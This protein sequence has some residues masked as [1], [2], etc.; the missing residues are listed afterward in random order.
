MDLGPAWLNFGESTAYSSL[1]IIIAIH[2][3]YNTVIILY[4][5]NLK[6]LNQKMVSKTG[7]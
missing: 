6:R 2:G 4:L 7:I 3:I 5:G 1:I